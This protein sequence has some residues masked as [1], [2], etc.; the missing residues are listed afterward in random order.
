MFKTW[1]RL[2]HPRVDKHTVILKAVVLSESHQTRIGFPE[3]LQGRYG[4]FSIKR[5]RLT[6]MNRWWFGY[7]RRF[8]RVFYDVDAIFTDRFGKKETFNWMTSTRTENA[9]IDQ[10]VNVFLRQHQLTKY[11]KRLVNMINR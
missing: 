5:V 1:F 2:F 10:C 8:K 4:S 9:A 3:D 6:C 7:Q 11:A